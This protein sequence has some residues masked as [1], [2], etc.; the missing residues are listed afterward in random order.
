MNTALVLVLALP[1]L[2]FLY[3]ALIGW[4]LP[5][6]LSGMVAS[7]ACG[8]AFVAALGVLLGLLALPTEERQV[9]LVLA[10]WINSGTFQAPFGFL[11]DPLSA[12]M[13]CVVTG[14]GFLI[15]VYATG[16]MRDHHGHLDPGYNRFFA[17][18]N[19][20]VLAMLV[21]VLA[22]NFVLL[23]MGWGGVGVCSYFLISFWFEKPENAAA[24]VKAFVVNA[25]GDV[26]LF[27]AAFTIFW[28]FGRVDYD[29]VFKAVQ[30]SQGAGSWN[31][32]A[33]LLLI[34]AAAK[35][36]QLPLHVWLPDA[37]AGPTPVSALI[38]AATMVTAG[39]YLIA[40][41]H[42]I[43]EHAPL[44]M[45]IVAVIGTITALFA[46]TVALVQQ[47]LKRV[48][49]YSTLSQLG[50]MFAGVGIG[51]YGS[52]IF[53]LTTHAFFKACLFLAAGVVI[54]ELSG[55]EDMRV[56]GGLRR[57]MPIVWGCFLLAAAANAGV[58][59]TSGFF[60]K[61][62]IVS[63][64]FAADMAPIGAVLLVTS[65]LTGFYMFRALFLTFHGEPAPEQAR[66]V[67][68]HGHGPSGA[69][70][71]PVALLALLALVGG[72]PYVAIEGYLE[73]TFAHYGGHPV[74]GL[75]PLAPI[76]LA[77]MLAG[78]IGI[79][80]A[81]LFYIRDRSLPRRLGQSMGGVYELLRNGWYIDD[82]Y[83]GALVVPGR[84]LAMALSGPVDTWVVDG[85]VRGVAA[86]VRWVGAELG[87][88]QTGFVRNYALA[89][90]AG[91]VVILGYMMRAGG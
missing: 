44:V 69:M 51:A 84:V 61:D 17:V 85:A 7:A 88:I 74:H 41:A 71:I 31:T 4:R 49:A 3:C 65:G 90:L 43:F 1:V 9:D 8:G 33:L 59:P 83:R 67:D 45:T 11:V 80:L 19:L 15:H 55:E 76:A 52:S 54:H 27:L 56:M 32:I 73:P 34:A 2:G 14:V 38:H 87:A 79:G 29:G 5:R 22:D 68:P 57:R 62:E 20:F 63:A 89:I 25:I 91:V 81:W 35:S 50:Y 48:I 66:L 77:T 10:P 60:S 46:A 16:Y 47:N 39:V 21:L 26:G 28:T 40:R 58:P 12:L 30:A 64:A 24:G 6:Q 18:M 78:L 75:G 70:V 82:L 53:H 42:P 86:T 37:M 72:L 36:A 13:I 23:M